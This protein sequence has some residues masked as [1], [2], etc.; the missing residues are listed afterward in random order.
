[1]SHGVE[2]E[3]DKYFSLSQITQINK[4]TIFTSKRYF[5]CN[6]YILKFDF[7]IIWFQRLYDFRIFYGYMILESSTVEL[8]TSLYG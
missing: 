8:E 3:V 4:W 5:T 1:M 2:P 7:R 6:I